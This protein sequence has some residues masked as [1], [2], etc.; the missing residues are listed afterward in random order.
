MNVS[1]TSISITE[2]QLRGAAGG[3]LVGGDD[4][5]GAK[6]EGFAA[7]G[8]SR[9]REAMLDSR[10]DSSRTWMAAAASGWLSPRRFRHSRSSRPNFSDA[11]NGF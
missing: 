1:V 6:G 3:A 9:R 5:E 2:H 7:G 4:F 8:G 11:I 10:A